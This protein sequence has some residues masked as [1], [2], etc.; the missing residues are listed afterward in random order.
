MRSIGMAVVLG[1]GGLASAGASAA[2]VQREGVYALAGVGVQGTVW[3]RDTPKAAGGGDDTRIDNR[4]GYTLGTGVRL[5]PFLAVEANYYGMA[6]K[7]RKEQVGAFGN[8]AATASVLGIL[9]V[10]GR[11]DLYGRVGGGY[12]RQAFV[13]KAGSRYAPAE[14]TRAAL[15]LGAGVNVHLNGGSFLRAEWNTWRPAKRSAVAKA[16]GADRFGTAQLALSYGLTF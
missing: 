2:D 7:A 3:E 5:T 4:L 13:P 9:P 14:D 8:Q 12:V 6:G 10:G 1:V 16:S 11:V 15:Q